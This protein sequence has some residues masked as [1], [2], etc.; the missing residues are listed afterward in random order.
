MNEQEQQTQEQQTQ[1]QD[2]SNYIEAIRDLKANTVPKEKYDKLA[3]ENRELLNSL[4]NGG[5]VTTVAAPDTK[6]IDELRK[7]LFSPKRD[8]SNLDYVT[9]TLELRKRVLDETGE[10][11]FIPKDKQNDMV[12]ITRSQQIADIYQDCIDFAD[13]NNERFT[14]E[15]SRRMVE[16]V[17]IKNRR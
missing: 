10:D 4:I 8:L 5:Q 17:P 3:N 7:E 15:L 11:C 16:N 6:S 9:K 13:G 14:A 12:A 1:E 2:N